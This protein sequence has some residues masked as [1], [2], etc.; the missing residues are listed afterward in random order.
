MA[1]LLPD[2]KEL[3]QRHVDT[4]RRIIAR[5]RQLIAELKAHNHST[6]QYE[7]LLSAFETSQAIFESDLAEITAGK[8]RAT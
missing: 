8:K 7:S 4:G 2:R 5:Q 6:K 3:A 1:S